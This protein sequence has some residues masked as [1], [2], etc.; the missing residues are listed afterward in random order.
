MVFDFEKKKSAAKSSTFGH[1]DHKN[2][3]CEILYGPGIS[4]NAHV[5]IDLRHCTVM[6]WKVSVINAKFHSSTSEHN[7]SGTRGVARP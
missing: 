3:L 2:P 1:D 4:M 6:F 7:R 5:S